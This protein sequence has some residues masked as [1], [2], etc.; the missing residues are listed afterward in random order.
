MD[1]AISAALGGYNAA[2]ARLDVSAANIANQ[3]STQSLDQSGRTINAPYVPLQVAQSSLAGGGVAASVLPVSPASVGQYD[4]ANPAA[5]AQGIVQVPNVDP[6]R[7]LVDATVA[8]YDAQAN[9]KTIKV[10]EEMLRQA[11]D[12]VG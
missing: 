10:Q 5:D 7:Q 3:A 12:I 9:L 6:V 4:P 11:L 8:G 1:S 2:V